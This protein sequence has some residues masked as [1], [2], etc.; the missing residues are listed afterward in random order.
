MPTILPTQRAP[1]RVADDAEPVVLPLYKPTK[2][3]FNF[4]SE[5]EVNQLTTHDYETYKEQLREQLDGNYDMYHMLLE[6]ELRENELREKDMEEE[7]N[8]SS[9]DSDTDDY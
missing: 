4:L 2:T 8:R 5:T 3:N 9:S 7:F 1:T 6:N